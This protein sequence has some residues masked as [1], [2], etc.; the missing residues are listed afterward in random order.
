MKVFSTVLTVLCICICTTTFSQSRFALL[1]KDFK[2]PILFTDSVT[3][4]QVT[5]GFFPVQNIHIDTLIANIKY[6]ESLVS[7]RQRAKMESFELRSANTVI[8]INRVPYAYG[9]RYNSVAFSNNGQVQAKITLINSEMSNKKSRE[10]LSRLLEYL[11]RNKSFYRSP[12]EITP[13]IYEVV[14]VADK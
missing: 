2:K 6:L 1:D 10:R 7:V 14:V 12:N 5:Q 13:K 9:D 3:V 4:E 11:E 8:K